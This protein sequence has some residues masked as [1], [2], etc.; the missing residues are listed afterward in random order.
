MNLKDCTLEELVNCFI[1]KPQAI[2]DFYKLCHNIKAGNTISLLFNPHRLDTTTCNAPVSV[3]QS[4]KQD[5]KLDGLARLYLYMLETGTNKSFYTAIQRGYNGVHYVNEFPP[6]VARSVYLKY[7]NKENNI[8]I[9]D[10]CAGWGGRMIGAASIPNTTYVAFEPS[11]ATYNGLLKLGEWLKCLQPTFNY[12][13]YN[14]PFEDN[15]LDEKFDVALTSPP[16]YDTEHYS[17]EETNSLNR[18]KTFEEWCDGFYAVLL[19]KAVNLLE[20]DAKFIINVGARLY[21]L[22]K[23]LY[24]ICN[25][26]NFYCEE[27]EG[28]LSGHGEG[29]EKFYCVSRNKAIKKNKKLF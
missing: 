11:T 24:R 5:D 15:T 14:M 26:N 3:Y 16:Y 13:I 1:T 21:P 2:E 18:Y 22:D 28:Y 6:F 4:M 25:E 23:E 7:R 8:K 19:K 27:I 20:D 17:D 9:L 10:P 12:K 29:R